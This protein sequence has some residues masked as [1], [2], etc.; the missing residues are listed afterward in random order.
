VE[1]NGAILAIGGGTHVGGTFVFLP[2]VAALL[3]KPRDIR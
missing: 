3:V 2:N 1:A